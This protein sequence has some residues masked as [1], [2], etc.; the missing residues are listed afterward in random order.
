MKEL[1]LVVLI[2]LICSF[3][4]CSQL[5]E[6]G[7]YL[8]YLQEIL[9]EAPDLSQRYVLVSD[10]SCSSCKEQVYQEVEDNSSKA[11]YIIL[12]PRNKAILRDRFHEAIIQNRLF[13]DTARLNLE[14]GILI[15]KAIEIGFRDGEWVLRELDGVFE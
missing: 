12:Q 1:R 8:L 13:I 14:R 3:A 7:N 11:V 6:K 2:G 5:S 9:G 10:Y 15:D 4:S